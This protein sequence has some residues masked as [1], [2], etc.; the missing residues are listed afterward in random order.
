MNVE[1]RCSRISL[2]DFN[3]LEGPRLLG[4]L[5]IQRRRGH[6]PELLD[7]ILLSR[8]QAKPAPR[9]AYRRNDLALYAHFELNPFFLS[10]T[11]TRARESWLQAIAPV[12]Q[13]LGEWRY[14]V[15]YGDFGSTVSL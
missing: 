15:S 3:K 8:C 10:P 1:L 2:H 4:F 12:I 14:Y 6:F 7:S 9:I 5:N 11:K 13:W